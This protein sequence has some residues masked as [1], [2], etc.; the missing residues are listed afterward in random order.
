[1]SGRGGIG[2]DSSR[3]GGLAS[4]DARRSPLSTPV[5][6]ASHIPRTILTDSNSGGAKQKASKC[7]VCNQGVGKNKGGMLMCSDCKQWCHY[8]CLGISKDV[9]DL[10]EKKIKKNWQCGKCTNVDE[11]D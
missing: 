8:L 9:F 7:P 1:M 4:A 2:K 10:Y 11:S 5:T 6:S 3:R